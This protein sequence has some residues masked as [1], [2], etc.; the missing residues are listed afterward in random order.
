MVINNSLIPS[1]QK[2]NGTYYAR[3]SAWHDNCLDMPHE[4]QEFGYVLEGKIN[5]LSIKIV[6]L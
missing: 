1:S 2:R 3:T 6:I 5:Y 4:G